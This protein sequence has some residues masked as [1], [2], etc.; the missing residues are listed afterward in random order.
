[1]RITHPFHPL[2]GHALDVVAHHVQWGEAR[3]YYRDSNGRRASLPASWTSLAPAD[4]YATAGDSDARFRLPD[5][6]ALAAL[7]EELDR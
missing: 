4:P 5:L 2:C 1:V 7:L 6:I 3:V